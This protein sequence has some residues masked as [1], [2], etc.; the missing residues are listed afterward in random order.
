M[1]TGTYQD[2]W[3]GDVE[4]SLKNGKLWFDSKRSYFLSGEIFPYKGST[5]IVKWME[6]SL[7]ADAYL[8]FDLD[9]DGKA[10]HM[11]MKPI[12]P[13]TDFSFDFQDLYFTRK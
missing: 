4:I 5:F 13:L 1:F 8:E 12:S 6:R 10:V 9:S 11:T 2:K 3:F 7:D